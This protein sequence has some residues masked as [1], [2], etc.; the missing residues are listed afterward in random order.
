MQQF[1]ALKDV[2]L[3]VHALLRVC[4]VDHENIVVEL[5]CHIFV[6]VLQQLEHSN[7]HTIRITIYLHFPLDG[8]AVQ[9]CELTHIAD[10]QIPPFLDR[11]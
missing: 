10:L 2:L 11:A 5:I 4:E 8:L 1:L 7:Q 9:F 3:L 6:L